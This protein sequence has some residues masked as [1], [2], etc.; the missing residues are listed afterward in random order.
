MIWFQYKRP[1]LDKSAYFPCLRGTIYLYLRVRFESD[2]AVL[3]KG[4]SPV[5][6][7]AELLALTLGCGILAMF[8]VF[9]FLEG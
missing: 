9:P 2:T 8:L 6:R 5:A 7:L 3:R 1:E 4:S